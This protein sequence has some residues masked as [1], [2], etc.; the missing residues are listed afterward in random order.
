M[1]VFVGPIRAIAILIGIVAAGATVQVH[2]AGDA[3]VRNL[4]S[5]RDH[6][7]L[8]DAL[9]AA[10]GGDRLE[11]EG[12]PIVGNFVIDRPLTLVGI[13]AG[14]EPPVLDG[15]GKGTV[16]T[17]TSPNVAVENIAL[18]HSGTTSNLFWFWG[19]AGVH[20]KADAVSL[21][22][23]HVYGNDWG[24]LMFG[25]RGS[26]V[27]DSLV[28]DNL[29]EGIKVMGGR[30]HRLSRNT[31]LRNSNGIVVD[32]LHS[33]QE[34]PLA[35]LNDPKAVADLAA[36]TKKAQRSEDVMIADNHVRGNGTFGISVTWH[37]RRIIV[38][39]NDVHLTGIERK[40]NLEAIAAVEHT[41]TA[42]LAGKSEAIVKRE[43]IGTGIY[44]F[45][46]V[47]DS[48]V[49]GND[50][51]D[52]FGAGIGLD[53]VDRNSVVSNITRTNQIGVYII[54][55]NENVI[56][57]NQVTDNTEF[58]IRIGGENPLTKAAANNLVALNDLT[59]NK[60]NAFDSSS[61]TLTADDMAGVIDALPYPEA[62]KEQLRRN[63]AMRTEILKSYLAVL[64]PASNR[65][66][67]G[68]HGNR[69]DDFDEEAEGFADRNGD[70]I[71]EAAKP[72][73]GGSSVDRHPL[74]EALVADLRTTP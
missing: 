59:G 11:V 36:D 44:L 10:R 34:S 35:R 4:T 25:G 13:S 32:V 27:E 29:R 73:Q 53:T 60:V 28:E 33:M 20:V 47:E 55:S 41:I 72:I 7:S 23:L 19:D 15:G 18:T 58:G 52:N 2:A 74:S 12:G 51:H 63:P 3:L 42:G 46:L 1:R 31:V 37:S 65:W 57:R 69:H 71:S 49:R 64:K 48:I 66:D 62:V 21:R 22:K 68:T 9:S 17:I 50:S 24:I 67:N 61:R 43:N 6:A 5:G 16:L 26:T 14:D 38:E 54:S 45:C 39:N 8:Q 30:E 56:E 40:P 70:G